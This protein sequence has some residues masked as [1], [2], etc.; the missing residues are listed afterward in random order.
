MNNNITKI[1]KRI[2]RMG[3][4]PREY[5]YEIVEKHPN[6]LTGDFNKDFEKVC[7]WLGY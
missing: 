1:A 3:D 4:F 2:E 6:E 7:E 5:V